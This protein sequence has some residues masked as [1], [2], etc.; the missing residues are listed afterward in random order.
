MLSLGIVAEKLTQAWEW[1]V[2][3]VLATIVPG[4]VRGVHASFAAASAGRN[5]NVLLTAIALPPFVVIGALTMTVQLPWGWNAAARFL[6]MVL[7]GAF[8]FQWYGMI[9][10]APWR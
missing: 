4:L 3:N 1:L 10:Y 5:P 7:A 6:I 9:P 2:A 8:G